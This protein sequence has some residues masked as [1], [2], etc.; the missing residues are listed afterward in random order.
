MLDFPSDII[1]QGCQ[2]VL[3]FLMFHTDC[4]N[5]LKVLHLISLLQ[6]VFLNQSY[7]RLN[8]IS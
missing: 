4:T 1:V 7:F 5:Y 6:G 8:E 2:K 3:Y